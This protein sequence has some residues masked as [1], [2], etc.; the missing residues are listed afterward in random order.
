MSYLFDIKLSGG[1]AEWKDHVRSLGDVNPGR[2]VDIEGITVLADFRPYAGCEAGVE[3]ERWARSV[4]S[5]ALYEPNGEYALVAVL[6]EDRK[7]V[8]SRDWSGAGGLFYSIEKGRL[9]VG[10]SVYEVLTAR[11]Q[12][13]FSALSCAEY[14]AF[15]YV[16]EPNT[17]FE[18]IFVVPR[19]KTVTV[20]AGGRVTVTGCNRLAPERV[21]VEE[22]YGGLRQ[23]IVDAHAKRVTNNNG[24]YLSGGIDSSVMAI[25]LKRDLGLQ[26]L[27]AISFATANA[28]YD[29]TGDARSV[30]AQLNIP[31]ERV[32]VDPNQAVDLH[33]LLGKSNFPY[34]GL[35][36]LQATAHRMEAIGLTGINIFAGQDTRLHTPHYNSVDRMALH[37]LLNYPVLR[38]AVA[39]AGG[40]LKSLSGN[41]R[42]RRGMLR[43]ELMQDLSA[44][45]AK[46]FFHYH[47]ASPVS[48][49]TTGQQL[50]RALGEVIDNN[51]DFT[52]GSREVFNDI[53]QV[54]WDRQY[55][56][57]IAY[58][59]GGTRSFGNLCSMPFYDRK[60]SN[61]SAGI[62]MPLALKTTS[63]RAG[64]GAAKKMV[65]KFVLREAYKGDLTS[66]M[67]F[68]DKAV[69][70]T[71]HL[72]LNGC[73][74]AYVSDY[75]ERPVFLQ[76]EI[77]H[78][79]GLKSLFD[80]G[81]QKNGLWQVNEYEEVVETHNLLFLETLARKY[82]VET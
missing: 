19:G 1:V 66:E 20:E 74:K 45:V 34:P 37:H 59:L 58:M 26:D 31:F 51:V 40:S 32:E 8:L 16:S 50:I 82:S 62:P 71:N 44:Y 9:I 77:G 33:A 25:T 29:E 47:K 11:E 12:R 79:L 15:E 2:G 67:I 81:L 21:D 73:L 4:R 3:L 78:R 53:V 41:G 18:D 80:K 48:Q 7:V 27:T 13:R 14:L 61:F 22:V 10:T 75:F 63:G 6:V 64:H 52:E 57:D 28:E 46:H 69:C 68:R 24:I 39:L 5:G 23:N 55:T 70:V 60:L 36:Y 42:N 49:S 56:S 54:A 17:L 65:N 72:Y 43:L 38:K 76:G 35:L 30:A